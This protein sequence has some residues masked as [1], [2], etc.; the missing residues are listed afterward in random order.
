MLTDAAIRR[1]PTRASAY[2]VACPSVRGFQVKILPSGHKVFELRTR[3]KYYR[4]GAVGLT[5]LSAARE[6]AR[7]ILSRLDQGLP[8]LEAPPATATLGALLDAWLAHQRALGR[9]RLAET[10]SLI[11][12]NLPAALLAK[13]ASAI[14]PADIRAVLATVHQRG[15]RVLSNRLRAHLHGI[16]QYGLRAD[17]DPARLADPVLFGITSNPVAAIPRD[18]GAE[19][20]GERVLTWTEV[21]ALWDAE[22]P[23][24]SWIGRQ[25]LRLLL[26]TGQRV[27]EVCQA[28]WG[29]FLI[30]ENSG[31]LALWTLPAARCKSKREHL[32]P[33]GPVAVGLL[34]E[35]H[36]VYPGEHLFPWRNVPGAARCWHPSSMGHVC[37]RAA[38]ELGLASFA[39]RDLR[40]TWK[41]LAGG[42]GLS[43]ELRNRIQGHALQDVGSRHYDR[44]S[45]L[46]EK[47]AAMLQW[48]RALLARLSE[49][50]NVVALRRA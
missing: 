11:R 26:L 7:V 5:P 28:R 32:I 9:R 13:P 36:E 47:R 25:A 35:L 12:R 17:H 30:P 23:A 40:R 37:V 24:L 22:E 18:A 49:G 41:T 4:L 48:E 27:N 15:A 29:E 50:G 38:R 34:K 16:F 3:G 39:A 43:L 2:R 46:E 31:E 10:E 44:H 6:K 21:R 19:R 1:L 8:A 20:A 14:V 33:L 45:Y 42:A